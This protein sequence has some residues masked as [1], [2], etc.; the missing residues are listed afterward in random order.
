[1]SNLSKA[2]STAQSFITE[3]H[4]PESYLQTIEAYFAP[5]AARL[6]QQAQS[7]NRPL[8]VGIHGC[9]GSGKSTLTD[10]LLAYFTAEYDVQA[11]GMSID[12]FYLTKA[13][14]QALAE[15]LHPLFATRGV[16]GT[17][18]IQVL[19]DVIQDFLD[20][21]LPVTVPRFDKSVDDQYPASAHSQI[22]ELPQIVIVEGWCV[23]APAGRFDALE[24]PMN[25]LEKTEDASQ[26]WRRYAHAQLSGSYA[27][28]FNKL[29]RIVMLKAP[30]FHTV[31]NWR[32]EQEQRLAQKLK[33][34]NL[35]VSQLMNEA[36][37]ERFVQFYQRITTD[38]L[39]LLPALADDVFH[40]DE[41]RTISKH[42]TKEA[43]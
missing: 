9:Q 31:V 38:S 3:H 35:D 6:V 42:T 16:P 10:F 17:H 37:I 43:V 4:L 23:A 2:K 1:M 33:A 29:D 34:Q 41:T 15:E 22:N 39:M 11:V 28:V 32:K 30:G 7:L 24:T 8:I 26:V 21:Q 36:Q 40:L 12:D 27:D 18:G 14:R 19:N 25:E 13:K 20:H 5:L